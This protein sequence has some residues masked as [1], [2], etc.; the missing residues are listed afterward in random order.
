MSKSTHFDIQALLT[1]APDQNLPQW[2]NL[3]HQI[4][5]AILT[6]K[7]KADLRLPPSR[8]LAKQLSLSRNTIISAFDQLIAEG[9]LV[10]KQGSGTYVANISPD[11]Q[12]FT[13]TPTKP[14]APKKLNLSQHGMEMAAVKRASFNQTWRY[15]PFQ[16]SLPD[17]TQFPRAEFAKLL[18]QVTKT[19]AID[20]LDYNYTGGLKPFKQ[21]IATYL[22]ASRGVICQPEQ[23]LIV[24]GSQAALDLTARLL[25]DKGNDIWFEHPGYGGAHSV[26]AAVGANFHAMPIIDDQ[27]QFAA[28][29]NSC[30]HPKLAYITPSHQHPTGATMSL[31]H[32]QTM[33]QLAE[34]R[35]FWL[36]EDDYD[37]EYR[38]D[39]RPIAALQGLD[40]SHRTIY[41]GTF[42]KI[43]SPALRCAYMVLPPQ[44]VNPFTAASFNAGINVPN[45]I[46]LALT[47]FINN[48]QFT[49]HIRKM[50]VLYNER[51]LTLLSAIDQHLSQYIKPM[52]TNAGMHFAV[53][54]IHPKLQILG[55]TQIAK[56]LR[57]NDISIRAL[58]LYGL[59]P[60]PPT[61]QGLLLGFAPFTPAQLTQAT[62]KMANIFTKLCH[63]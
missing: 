42:S 23:V 31:K 40:Q 15:I 39:G 37:S 26:F 4:K 8:T 13:P 52:S 49:S 41:I 22:G 18:S 51:R 24:S 47:E 1:T 9:Y 21:A 2:R 20:Q 35:N 50:R 60:L 17:L 48:G 34:E 63:A 62:V 6:D 25:I 33:L 3:Y 27:H 16:S 7:L 45:I 44:L 28:A 5:T 36:I 38:Y 32:R 11:Q 57:Q 58:S 61:Q 53:K 29:I 30:P 59:T 10:A 56:H 12:F 19:A 54:I 55:D 46:Q 43:L 14:P